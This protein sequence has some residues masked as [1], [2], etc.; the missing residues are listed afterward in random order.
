M[1]Y[2]SRSRYC[3]NTSSGM[4]PR[5]LTWMPCFFAQARTSDV[6]T[7]SRAGTGLG[8]DRGAE[9][10]GAPSLLAEGSID[11]TTSIS[12]S[13]WSSHRSTSYVTKSQPTRMASR[14]VGAPQTSQTFITRV[15][16]NASL[17]NLRRIP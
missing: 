12:A 3:S 17:H 9:V 10:G 1:I 14:S 11:S 7:R 8:E 5:S 4:R 13:A 16:T 2:L 6:E 15:T